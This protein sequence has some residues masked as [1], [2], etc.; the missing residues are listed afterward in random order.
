MIFADLKNKLINSDWNSVGLNITPYVP[1]GKK[2]G[3]VE[4]TY[5]DIIKIEDNFASINRMIFEIKL[6]FLLCCLY[7]DI[8]FEEDCEF[9]DEDYDFFAANGFKKWLSKV[10][11]ND[12]FEFES[13]LKTFAIDVARKLNAAPQQFNVEEIKSLLEDPKI[14]QLLEWTGKEDVKEK[15][16][17]MIK[18]DDN[19]KLAST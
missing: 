1:L 17:Q 14:N 18:N 6:C 2:Y 3:I 13:I 4:Q 16:R 15:A 11:N 8:E 10:T 12:S 9:N 19:N 7:T 5:D